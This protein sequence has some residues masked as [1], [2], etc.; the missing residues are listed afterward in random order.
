[1]YSVAPPP[2]LR[3]DDPVGE[4]VEVVQPK[5]ERVRLP[6]TAAASAQEGVPQRAK[7]DAKHA[8]GHI[9]GIFSLALSTVNLETEQSN[10]RGFQLA[11]IMPS[12]CSF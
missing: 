8:A 5:F 1:M 9:K 11:L 3:G 2:S 7:Q 10:E 4:S 6:L 12:L